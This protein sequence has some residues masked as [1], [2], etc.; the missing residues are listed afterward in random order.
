MPRK[1]LANW[2]NYPRAEAEFLE[3]SAVGPLREFVKEPDVIARGNGRCYGD[4][5][6]GTRVVSTLRLDRFLDLDVA[7][8]VVECESG[9][10]LADILD[11]V[12]PRGYFLPVTPGTKFITVGG[13]VAADVH[14]KNHHCEGTFSN[15][16][17]S[18]ELITADG[19]IVR[20][21]RD[22][23]ADLFWQTCGGMGLTGVILSVRFRL[24]PIET[25]Y[26]SQRTHKARDIDA[27]MRLFDESTDATYSVAWIDCLA[28]SRQRGRSHL[29][30]GEHTAADELPPRFRSEPLKIAGKG[31]LAVP[32]HFPA[33]SVNSLS[34]RA[35]NTLYYHRVFG[36][37]SDAVVHFDGYFYPLDG[38]LDW[39]RAYGKPG[40]V[41]YQFVLPPEQ[42]Y[43]GL[44]KILDLIQ[45]SGQGSP[46]AV[47]KLFGKPDPNAVMS[48]PIEGYTLALDFKVNDAVFGLLD[49]LDE[50]VAAH[51]G[52]IY[53]AKD[54]RMKPEMF[55]N[56]YDRK[57]ASGHF[58]SLL[59][60]RL[61]F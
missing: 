32:F 25:A 20:C 61:R 9:V 50:I 17:I 16:V 38:I 37:T 57:V 49:E 28:P 51:N 43:D 2:G 52:R 45:R 6:L 39:N 55:A 22:E 14:G 59:S 7:N 34:V 58:A 60:K 19:S 4:A 44:V 29:I 30:L 35:L 26:I 33:F 48:F 40:F 36:E 41:Q 18:L 15:H 3:P 8:G 54:A 10:L 56:T 46:L 5:S 24:K 12:V 27:V 11:V 21:S 31:T 13:A 53:L 47:L 1:V 42:S 23:N